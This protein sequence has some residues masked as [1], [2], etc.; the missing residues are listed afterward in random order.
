MNGSSRM[1]SSPLPTLDA[2]KAQAKQLRSAL[3]KSDTMISHS[4]SLE[5]IAGQFGFRDWNTLHAAIGNSPGLTF[6]TGQIVSGRYLGKAFAGKVVGHQNHGSTGRQRLTVLF[7]EPVNV[8]RF[9]NM[10]V[11]RYRVSCTLDGD[12]HCASKTSD[13]VPHFVF[14][15]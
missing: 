13:G 1:P 12:G 6:N 5:L 4:R 9:E 10:P 15:A 11:F 14:D 3:E 2:V 8:S 7:D